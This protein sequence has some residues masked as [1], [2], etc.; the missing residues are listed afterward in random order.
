[1]TLNA[2]LHKKQKENE[3]KKRVCL[4]RSGAIK[5][6]IMTNF[7]MNAGNARKAFQSLSTRE[8]LNV[9]ISTRKTSTTS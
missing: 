9:I 5:W 7:E 4:E 3:R 1:M 8:P 6:P 2:P